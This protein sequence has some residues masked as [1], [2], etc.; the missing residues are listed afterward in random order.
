MATVEGQATKF[1]RE[2]LRP[3]AEAEQRKKQP[4]EEIVSFCHDRLG[5][6]EVLESFRDACRI[7]GEIDTVDL[8]RARQFHRKFF[9]NVAGMRRK[10]QHTIPQTGGFA[11]VVR[12]KD[13]RFAARFPDFLNIAIKLLAGERIESSKWFVHEKDARVWR[14]RARKRNALFHSTGKLVDVR[15]LESAEPDQF[16]IILRD[17]MSIFSAQIRLQFEPEEHVSKNSEPWK[18]GRLLKHDEP[19]AAG[20]RD[21]FTISEHRAAIRFF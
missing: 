2:T 5:L 7:A 18:K 20:R 6:T 1:L 14:E 13:D 16:E 11:D 10:K 15:M 4:R 9:L 21:R 3:K 12:N 8:A 17:V 19:F